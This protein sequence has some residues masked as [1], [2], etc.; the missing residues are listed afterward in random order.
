MFAIIG[1]AAVIVGL[2]LLLVTRLFDWSRERPLPGSGNRAFNIIVLILATVICMV[3]I[4]D[5]ELATVLSTLKEPFLTMIEEVDLLVSLAVVA[6]I[7][8]VFLSL[9]RSRKPQ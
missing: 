1:F 2:S 9:R 4:L 8:I 5:I 6:V 7:L 3:L